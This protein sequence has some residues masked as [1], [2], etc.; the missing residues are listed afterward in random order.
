MKHIFE[1]QMLFS[2]NIQIPKHYFFLNVFCG[3]EIHFQSYSI[4]SIY[5]NMFLFLYIFK[6]QKGPKRV[7]VEIPSVYIFIPL[8]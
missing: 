6:W 7:F 8:V 4:Y 3:M 1:I 5:S 2:F